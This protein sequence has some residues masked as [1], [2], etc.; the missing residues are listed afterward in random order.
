MDFQ[1][2]LC[3][4]P[5]LAL[6]RTQSW[7]FLFG[8][9]LIL[10]RSCFCRTRK[11]TCY[12]MIAFS[13]PSREGNLPSPSLKSQ[14]QPPP[15]EPSTLRPWALTCATLCS[16]LT[17]A[18]GSSSPCGQPHPL[19]AHPHHPIHIHSSLTPSIFPGEALR[20][21]SSC[22]NRTR[23]GIQSVTSTSKSQSPS[24]P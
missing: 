14:F 6:K 2:Q 13:V 16:C 10:L 5:A 1:G 20:P 24:S 12:T 11:R 18:S 21:L 23:L 8:C 3:L 19:P 15:Q 7:H 4:K 9:F 17:P 22:R